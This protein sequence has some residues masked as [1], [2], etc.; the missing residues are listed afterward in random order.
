MSKHKSAPVGDRRGAQADALVRF[1][2]LLS[3]EDY[4]AL[5]AELERPLSPA[6]RANLLKTGPESPAE[7]AGRYGWDLSPVPYCAH[8][9]RLKSVREAPGQTLEHRSGQYYIQ[10]VASML[11]VELFDFDGLHDPLVLDMAASPGGK[12]THLLDRTLDHGLLIANDQAAARIT[13]LRLVL[14]T[15]GATSTAITNLPGESFGVWFPETF[16]RVLLDAPCSMQGLRSTESH[17]MRAITD[18]E[19]QSL[20]SRQAR[21][22]ASAVE[23]LKVGGQVVYST[24]TLSPEE[25]EGVLAAL[26][27]QYSGSVRIEDTAARLPYPALA[28]ER[29]GETVY[30]AAV[31][32][33]ARLW[34]HTYGTAGFFAAL[35]TKTAPVNSPQ[36]AP[37]QR[38]PHRDDPEPVGSRAVHDLAAALMDAY[39]FDLEAVLSEYH[40]TLVKHGTDV[41]ALPERFMWQ[42]RSL[43]VESLGL[44]LGQ[45]APEGFIPGYEWVSRFW[46]DFSQGR[47]LLAPDQSKRWQHGE[48]IRE[49]PLNTFKHGQIV[50]AVDDAGRFLGCG[51]VLSDRLK[52]LLPRRLAQQL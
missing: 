51:R 33:A 18:H 19:R 28:L 49:A 21:L 27:R 44:G 7:W 50:L 20:A 10:D 41:R 32:G 11:P 36:V 46:K 5:L 12:T 8:G 35:V 31:R 14:Q 23:A 3:A 17:P 4:A 43:P 15:W 48:D 40:L 2:P 39:G 24:C 25:D 38:G 52:N 34:P 26:L 42:F 45:S 22:L 47:I 30:P 1:Q 13:A 37:P 9:Y 6:L 29:Y 16:D